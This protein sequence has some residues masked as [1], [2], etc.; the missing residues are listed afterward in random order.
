MTAVSILFTR[1]HAPHPYGATAPADVAL[2]LNYKASPHDLVTRQVFSAE[3]FDPDC[4][5]FLQGFSDIENP[6]V[7]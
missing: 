6:L 1:I 7:F 5:S 4:L 2:C 3:F